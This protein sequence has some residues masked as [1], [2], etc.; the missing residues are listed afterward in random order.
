VVAP[1][2][3]VEPLRELATAVYVSPPLLP[4][5][6]LHEY[7]RA[8]ELEPHLAE[9]R[10]FLRPRRDALLETFE[11]LMPPDA[12]WTRPEGGYFLWLELPRQLLAQELAQ[13]AAA[14]GIAFVP[15]G[16]FFAGSGGERGARLSFSF[17]PVGEVWRGARVLAELVAR[18]SGERG[19]AATPP[20]NAEPNGEPAAVRPA[21]AS[22][23]E[24]RLHQS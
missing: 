24:S 6:A 4:Q 19:E 18:S 12:S 20:G 8:G 1:E 17:A 10:A 13:R 3:L 5:A 9:L 23:A 16:G 11:Q 21:A 14:S 22:R 15:G 7:V 2:W